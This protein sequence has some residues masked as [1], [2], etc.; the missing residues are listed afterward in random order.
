M[1]VSIYIHLLLIFTAI[2]LILAILFNSLPV[3]NHL[4][5]ERNEKTQ[6]SPSKTISSVKNITYIVIAK[7]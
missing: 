2:I 7:N 1:S 5:A 6:E 3:S 4:L